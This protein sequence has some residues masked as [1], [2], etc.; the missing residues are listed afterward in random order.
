MEAWCR[1]ATHTCH[2]EGIGS[3][4]IKLSVGMIRE[5]KDVRYVPQLNKN[6][7]SV[8]TLETQGLRGTLGEGVLK[9]FSGFLVIL[10]GIRRNLY[11]L[12][13]S[14]DTKNLAASEC[15]KDDSSKL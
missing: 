12:N 10:N 14:A 7:I 15:L 3:F 9:M 2:I 5:L 11:Y 13:G 1:S 4:H 6:L 8:R